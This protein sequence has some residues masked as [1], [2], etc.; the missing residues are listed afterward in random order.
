MGA[1]RACAVWP[2]RAQEKM[3]SFVTVADDQST[4]GKGTVVV[5]DE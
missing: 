1:N 4:K 2:A 5:Q 3:Y